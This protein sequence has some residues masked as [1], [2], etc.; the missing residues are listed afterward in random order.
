MTYSLNPG[1]SWG[2]LNGKYK[3]LDME[4]ILTTDSTEMKIIGNR[5]IGFQGNN[6][7]IKMKKI[8]R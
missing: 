5:L 8:V 6:D 3:M 2:Y 7:T 1:T 4:W